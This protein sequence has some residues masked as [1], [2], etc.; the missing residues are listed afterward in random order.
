MPACDCVCTGFI[1]LS[2]LT[3]DEFSPKNDCGVFSC[4][5]VFVDDA[6]SDEFVADRGSISSSSDAVLKIQNIFSKLKLKFQ[7][8]ITVIVVRSACQAIS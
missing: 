3:N 6:L 1:R 2:K 4:L 8:K 7:K 5:F